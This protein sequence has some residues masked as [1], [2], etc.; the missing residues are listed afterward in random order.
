MKIFFI[1]P[2]NSKASLGFYFVIFILFFSLALFQL[3][4]HIKNISKP[5][6]SQKISQSAFSVTLDVSGTLPSNGAMIM[7][8]G[9]AYFPL[10]SQSTSVE[11]ERTS[12]VEIFCRDDV[13]FSVVVRP[14]AGTSVITNGGEIMCKRGM[15]YICRAFLDD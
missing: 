10:L 4:S 8:N 5:V 1:S 3:V 9:E 13:N 12:V 14:A 15:N 7:V 2:K 6:V 11:L